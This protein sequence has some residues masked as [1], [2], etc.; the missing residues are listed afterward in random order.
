MKI[1]AK[2]IWNATARARRARAGTATDDNGIHF[3]GLVN[4]VDL[5]G[6][7]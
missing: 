2:P 3:I 4:V 1:G 5:K 6:G 7:G